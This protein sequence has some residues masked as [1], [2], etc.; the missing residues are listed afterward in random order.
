MTEETMIYIYDEWQHKL[1]EEEVCKIKNHLE[2]REGKKVR[3]IAHNDKI[4]KW[5]FIFTDLHMEHVG[6]D[7]DVVFTE[8]EV[9]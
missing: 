1:T 8:S 2:A 3:I 9:I 5:Y 4:Q 6:M 7:E